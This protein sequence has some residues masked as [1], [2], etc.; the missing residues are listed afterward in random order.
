MGIQWESK[1]RCGIRGGTLSWKGNTYL[2]ILLS[3]ILGY[4]LIV[5]DISNGSWH[6]DEAN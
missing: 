6:N 1:N 4:T 2:A 5:V 3:C